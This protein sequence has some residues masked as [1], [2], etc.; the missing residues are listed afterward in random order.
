LA[1]CELANGGLE[2][3]KSGFLSKK[4]LKS[5]FQEQIGAVEDWKVES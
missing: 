5:F 1:I 4:I 2:G 3:R